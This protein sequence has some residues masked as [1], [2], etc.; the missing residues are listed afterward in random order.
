MDGSPFPPR[1]NKAFPCNGGEAGGIKETWSGG[2]GGQIR[3]TY[4]SPSPRE[5]TSTWDAFQPMQKAHVWI[6]SSFFK[7]FPSFKSPFCIVNIVNCCCCLVK[8]RA[9]EMF[10]NDYCLDTEP[11]TKR[12]NGRKETT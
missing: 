12:R 7:N 11:I 10:Q 5:N 1:L 6:L 2:E 9:P 8:H 4:A 3:V